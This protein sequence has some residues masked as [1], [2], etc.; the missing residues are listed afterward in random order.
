LP[1]DV[2]RVA[3]EVAHEEHGLQARHGDEDRRLHDPSDRRR[4]VE[5]RARRMKVLAEAL[6]HDA[7]EIS[8]DDLVPAVR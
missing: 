4:D 7:V 2:V 8:D 5:V 3:L 1:L 6:Q